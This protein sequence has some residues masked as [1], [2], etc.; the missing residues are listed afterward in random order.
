M[1]LTFPYQGASSLV[2]PPQQKRQTNKI[3][4]SNTAYLPKSK[5]FAF[6]VY[7]KLDICFGNTGSQKR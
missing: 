6:K 1:Q 4:A 7:L 2:L 5:Y 3:L